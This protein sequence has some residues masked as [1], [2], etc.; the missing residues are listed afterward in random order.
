M[1]TLAAA[2]VGRERETVDAV[3]ITTDMLSRLIRGTARA[4]PELQ[5]QLA[6]QLDVDAAA[7][8]E[9]APILQRLVGE[10]RADPDGLSAQ[11]VR[12]LCR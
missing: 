8:F 7:L 9:T 2:V 11:R 10:H 4:T 6:E 5:Q 3:G 12:S 1:P